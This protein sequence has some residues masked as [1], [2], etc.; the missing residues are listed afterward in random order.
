VRLSRKWIGPLAALAIVVGASMAIAAPSNS[1]KAGTAG[2]SRGAARMSIR[3]QGPDPAKQLSALAGELGVTPSELRKALDAVHE[4][5]GPPPR[6]DRRPSRSDM[7]K[8]CTTE[9][10]ALA[11]EL[12][13]DGDKVRA[14][15]KTV[16]KQGIEDAVKAGR[17]SRSQADRMESRIDSAA[18]L[19]PLGP[20]MHGGPGCGPPPGAPGARNGS[21]DG[22]APPAGGAAFGGA[23]MGAPPA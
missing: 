3:V 12:N 18:C 2:K 22:G 9:T 17:L 23:F 11:T 5:L 8:R 20:G 19:P 13:L 10:D 6:P 15:I 1:G 14:A 16:A 4:R 7:E 21:S